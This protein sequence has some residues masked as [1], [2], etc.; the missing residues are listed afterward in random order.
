[1]T[2]NF[3]I[4]MDEYLPLRDVVFNTLRQAI[5]KGELKPGERL[6]EIQLAKRLGV[7]R[8][9]VR[10]AIRKLELEGLVLMV[11]RKGA[12]VADITSKDLEDVLEVRTALE[13]LAVKNAC[14]YITEEQIQE[15]KKAAADFK[16]ALE[17]T[18]LIACAEADMRFHEIIYAATNNRRLI[19]MLN[20]LKE[21]MY[22]YR[23][24][25]LKDKRTYKVLLE[26]HDTIRRALK[27]H[28]KIKAGNAIRSHI[29]NQ[30]KSILA[31]L[32]EK[33]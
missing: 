16:E 5:L 17:G 4:Q 19:Q 22:R 31:S 33:E 30:K 29:E 7:S 2:D 18:D 8:T 21:Q 23:M 14:D 24:E 11:P 15:L 26:E 12:E 3:Q 25:Y 1:M 28:D 13:E 10:E 32:S 6:M 27:K 9:P 20:N